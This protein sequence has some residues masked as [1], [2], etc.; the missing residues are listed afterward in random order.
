MSLKR[1]RYWIMPGIKY[2]I[3][4]LS[5]CMPC[6]RRHQDPET[7]QLGQLPVERL[8]PDK[9]PFTYVGVDFFGQM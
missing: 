3:S 7:Q 1:Q 6:T 4:V 5:K 8:L 9:P 2:V